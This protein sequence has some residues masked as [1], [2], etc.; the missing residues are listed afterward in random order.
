LANV[1]DAKI[2]RT[3]LLSLVVFKI[4]VRQ[5]NPKPN[6][7]ALTRRP[8]ASMSPVPTQLSA[9]AIDGT[10]NADNANTAPNSTTLF[11]NNLFNI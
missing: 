4:T 2:V 11:F 6:P 5:K 3:V 10:I 9:G 1:D 8:F 7:E